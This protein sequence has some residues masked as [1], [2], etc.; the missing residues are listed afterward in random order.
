MRKISAVIID[1]DLLF[2]TIVKGFIDKT[3]ILELVNTFSNPIEALNFL[4]SQQVDLIF[5]DVEMP[6]MTG[7]QFIKALSYQPEIILITS[8][9]SYAISAF[10][11]QVTDYLL[12][13]LE[14]YARFMRAVNLVK[15]SLIDHGKSDSFFIKENNKLVKIS[16]EDI[17]YMEAHGDYVK[18]Y[19]GDKFHLMFSSMKS[20]IESLPQEEFLKVHRS[21]II[22]LDKVVSIEG[23]TLQINNAQIPFSKSMRETVLNR[24]MN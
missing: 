2:Q 16:F 20:I 17:D 10:E 18:I 3:D 13:P 12:K 11:H 5:L 9:E 23:N 1:D 6:E 22:R 19:I 15:A 21:Y 7:L 4:D 8:S 14:D 24:I